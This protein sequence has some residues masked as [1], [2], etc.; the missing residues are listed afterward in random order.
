VVYS[1]L[2][3]IHQSFPLLDGSFVLC[4]HVHGRY[5]VLPVS[6]V[7]ELQLHKIVGPCHYLYLS[8]LDF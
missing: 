7:I 3:R 1:L 6:H 5:A 4:A 2:E 8:W